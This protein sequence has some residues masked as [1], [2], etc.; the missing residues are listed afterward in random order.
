MDDLVNLVVYIT[1]TFDFGKVMNNRTGIVCSE[2]K[3]N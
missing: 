2:L 3:L 1:Q